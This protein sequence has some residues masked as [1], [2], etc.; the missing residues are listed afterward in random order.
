MAVGSGRVLPTLSRVAVGN[1]CDH[2]VA[3]NLEGKAL[4]CPF[5][6]RGKTSPHLVSTP[7][8][9][10]LS[11]ALSATLRLHTLSY[12][13]SKGQQ[14]K[15]TRGAKPRRVFNRRCRRCPASRRICRRFEWGVSVFRKPKLCRE[16][17]DWW[18]LRAY[19]HLV[20]TPCPY[21]LSKAK[22][23]AGGAVPGSVC[24]S[25]SSFSSSRPRYCGTTGTAD[26][27][28]R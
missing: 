28:D 16:L 27:I 24:S 2:T 9:R 18:V 17:C 1:Y 19:I 22:E 21:A 14:G 10:T 23:G 13:L 5:A 7:C 11:P 4:P 3:R 12:A 15:R 8:L 6:A 20:P 26:G 25:S